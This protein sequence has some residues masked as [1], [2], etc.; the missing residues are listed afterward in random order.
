MFKLD[1]FIFNKDVG[2]NWSTS[3]EVDEWRLGSH[4][5]S[6]SMVDTFKKR[7]GKF[8]DSEVRFREAAFHWPLADSLYSYIL[9][10]N[11]MIT[12]KE[13]NINRMEKKRE[14]QLV[15]VENAALFIHIDQCLSRLEVILVIRNKHWTWSCHIMC[16]TDVR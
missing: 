3:R 6:A 15:E 13:K 1:R 4:V 10:M 5:V 2:K 14:K 9:R 11:S 8:L 16:R 7:L 12:H